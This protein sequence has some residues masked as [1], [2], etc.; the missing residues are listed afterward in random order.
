MP[1]IQPGQN[2]SSIASQA[3]MTPAQF[4]ALN[5]QFAGQGAGY[6]QGLAN[7]VQVGQS[8]NVNPPANQPPVNTPPTTTPPANTTPAQSP[9]STLFSN[10]TNNTAYTQTP[11]YQNALN[12]A[13]GGAYNMV[14]EG[15]LRTQKLSQLQD[16]INTINQIYDQQLGKARVEGQGRIGSNTAISAARGLTGSMRGQTLGENVL[17]YNRQID[18]GINA[19]RNTAIQAV[20]GLADQYAVEEAARRRQALESGAKDYIA[21]IRDQ[22]KEKQTGITTIAAALYAQGID[23]TTMTEAELTEATK[24]LKGISNAD[25]LSAYQKVKSEYE[26]IS[27]ASKPATVQEYEYAKKNGY[28]G[29]FT[30]YQNE[31]ANRKASASGSGLTPY[32]QFTATQSISK[33]TQKRT[34][35]AREIARQ[36]QLITSSYQNILNGGDRSLN[37]QAIITSFNKI[38]DPTS[39]VR[40]SE[41]DRTAEGQALLQRLQGKVDNF[42]KGGAGVAIQTLKEATDIANEYLKKS[43]AS[44][45]TENQRSI[46]FATQFGLN[47]DFVTSSGYSPNSGGSTVQTKMGTLNLSTWD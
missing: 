5:P 45:D 22:E 44:I 30:E 37:T 2:L 28:T 21:Y 19:E 34:E 9:I 7:N 23:P 46:Q 13:Q 20:K 31:D 36:A 29:S 18:A 32:Q 11:Q 14:D 6:Y 8:Y 40:E 1:L 26:P 25:I 38:L 35:S 15:A 41:Y 16:R 10:Y 43:K 12:I 33:D 47:P 4:A 17:D 24:K 42:A 3:G 39:V 27:K